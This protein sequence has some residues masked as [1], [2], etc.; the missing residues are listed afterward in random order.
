MEGKISLIFSLENFRVSNMI[1]SADRVRNDMKAYEKRFYERY[2]SN[3]FKIC[4]CKICQQLEL[5]F[6]IKADKDPNDYKHLHESYL[7]KKISQEKIKK[8]NGIYQNHTIVI[9]NNLVQ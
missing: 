2:L 1:P 9:H 8:K 6:M 4:D 7:N 3:G 5:K